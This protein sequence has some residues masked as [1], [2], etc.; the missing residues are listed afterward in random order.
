MVAF[1]TMLLKEVHGF[2][3]FAEAVQSQQIPTA[4]IALGCVAMVIAFFGYCGALRESY[5]M[6]MTVN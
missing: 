3:D 6:S 1:G 5:C 2:G 4:L